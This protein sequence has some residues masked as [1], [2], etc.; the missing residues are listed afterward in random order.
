MGGGRSPQI[1]TLPFGLSSDGK[2][3]GSSFARRVAPCAHGRENRRLGREKERAKKSPKNNRRRSHPGMA[4]PP[5]SRTGNSI[6]KMRAPHRR[7]TGCCRLNSSLLSDRRYRR[8]ALCVQCFSSINLHA[9]HPAP[10][11]DRR[12]DRL[13]CEMGW[14]TQMA[15]LPKGITQRVRRGCPELRRTEALTR[16]D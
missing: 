9:D 1:P 3:A 8:S 12:Q 7:L 10:A 15:I 16:A 4:P 11:G 14:V 6:G 5:V 13:D 2:S